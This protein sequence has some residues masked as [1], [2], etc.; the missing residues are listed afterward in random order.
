MC[1]EVLTKVP[2]VK[3]RLD[4]DRVKFLILFAPRAGLG[5]ASGERSEPRAIGLEPATLRL[6]GSYR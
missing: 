1:D 2:T 4:D 5:T 3:Q 6:T